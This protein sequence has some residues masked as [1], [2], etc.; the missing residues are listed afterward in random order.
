MT[1][2]LVALVVCVVVGGGLFFLFSSQASNHAKSIAAAAEANEEMAESA[3][4][5]QVVAS[6]AIRD[7]AVEEVRLAGVR[8]G[9]LAACAVLLL[10]IAVSLVFVG[11]GEQTSRPSTQGAG[12]G[13]EPRAGAAGT[14][15]RIEQPGAPPAPAPPA[16]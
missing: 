15:A 2:R 4:Q 9:L 5:Q 7:A 8:N 1:R 13:P 12:W 14:S 6:W 3:P 11:E 10:S 16:N